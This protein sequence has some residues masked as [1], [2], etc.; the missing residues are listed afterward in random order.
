MTLQQI[1]QAAHD[2]GVGVMKLAGGDLVVTDALGD[3]TGWNAIRKIGEKQYSKRD[4][5]HALGY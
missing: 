2:H 4:L 1:K 3:T 5:M